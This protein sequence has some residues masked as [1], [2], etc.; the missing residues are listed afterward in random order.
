MISQLHG[1]V[2]SKG[3]TDVVVD[4]GGVGYLVSVPLST[5]DAVPS[6]GESVTLLTIMVVREDLMQLF[7]FIDETQRTAFR[8][9]ISIQGIGGRIALGILSSTTLSQLQQAIVHDDVAT[10]TRL[11][12]IGKKTAERIVIELR[13]KITAAT[14]EASIDGGTEHAAAGDA[15]QA[16]QA[17]GYSKAAAE[18]AVATATKKHP[19]LQSRE[20]IIRTALKLA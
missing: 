12:G 20:D 10:L 14:G 13:D 9:L 4:C 15:V 6:I 19:D 3:T 1:S 11:P 18:K 8:L 17:L 16:L 5:L 7:G 2:V